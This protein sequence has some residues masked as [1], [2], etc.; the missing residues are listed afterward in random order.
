[1]NHLASALVLL[2][3][4]S[5]ENQTGLPGGYE[6]EVAFERP[7]LNAGTDAGAANG[8]PSIFTALKSIGLELASKKIGVQTLNVDSVA[9]PSEN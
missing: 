3:R 4:K 6:F 7:D 8:G 2:L 5:V 9:R 1:M